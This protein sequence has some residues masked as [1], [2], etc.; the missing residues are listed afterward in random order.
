MRGS[1]P[2]IILSPLRPR[3]LRRNLHRQSYLLRGRLNELRGFA[4]TAGKVC[5]KSILA[6][7]SRPKNEL[8]SSGPFI[9]LI[10]VVT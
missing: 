10:S 1:P 9:A 7:L 6:L 4:Q 3:L 2:T 8:Y 5:A